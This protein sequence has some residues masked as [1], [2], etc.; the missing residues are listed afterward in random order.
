MHF[1][2]LGIKLAIEKKNNS[3]KTN[4]NEGFK[5]QT[6]RGYVTVYILRNVYTYHK[7]SLVSSSP[8]LMIFPSI[9]YSSR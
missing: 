4:G 8:D 6:F 7:Y 1:Y 5:F 2:R 9:D 3:N